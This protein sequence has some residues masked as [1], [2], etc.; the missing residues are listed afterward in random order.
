MERVGEF[1]TQRRSKRSNSIGAHP[2]QSVVC[3]TSVLADNKTDYQAATACIRHESHATKQALGMWA[4]VS[5]EC[6]KQG[7]I[8]TRHFTN[9][10]PS[11]QRSRT[12]KL[13]RLPPV[14]PKTLDIPHH[15]AL[16]WRLREE[17]SLTSK[18]SQ[19]YN[20]Y[21]VPIFGVYPVDVNINN[22]DG[23]YWLT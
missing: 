11:R 2:S 17:V 4:Q 20:V 14:T 10:L 22:G 6:S 21:F 5:S 15:K 19:T 16:Q 9:S 8:L 3:W 13:T 7:W 1:R 23:K 18:P 12:R